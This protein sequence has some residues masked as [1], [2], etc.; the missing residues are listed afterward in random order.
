MLK[1]KSRRNF[2]YELSPDDCGGAPRSAS[3][4]APRKACKRVDFNEEPALFSYNLYDF[5]GSC[6]L[7]RQA[8]PKP[9]LLSKAQCEK[10]S[11]QPLTASDSQLLT[12]LMRNGTQ[13]Q[14]QEP[15]RTRDQCESKSIRASEV[16]CAQVERENGG[17][18]VP[19]PALSA[20]QQS[21]DASLATLELR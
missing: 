5:E 2:A 14:S 13:S 6:N 18:G 7:S 1:K 15:A 11:S 4:D 8:T 12:P 3:R 16:S 19:R 10:P 17:S 21:I 20:Y 9:S